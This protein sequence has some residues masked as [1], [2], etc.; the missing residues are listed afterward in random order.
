MQRQQYNYDCERCDYLQLGAIGQ[1]IIWCR[2]VSSGQPD[3][4]YNLYSNRQQRIWLYHCS[5]YYCIGEQHSNNQRRARCGNMRRRLNT[6][7]GNRSYNLYM[8]TWYRTFCNYRNYSNC[9]PFRNNDIYHN[10]IEWRGLRGYGTG[11]S[12]G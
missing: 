10:R 1:F 6:T 11:N 7:D 8:G 9:Q 3:S 2:P 4:N 12:N 5:I